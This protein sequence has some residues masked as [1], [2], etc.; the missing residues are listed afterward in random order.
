MESRISMINKLREKTGIGAG[1]ANKCLML[2]DYEMDLA[3]RIAEY[4]GIAVNKGYPVGRVIREYWTIKTK[5][6]YW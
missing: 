2:A 6:E 5:E 1:L 3:I 4:Y